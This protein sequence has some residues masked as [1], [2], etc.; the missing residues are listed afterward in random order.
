MD[1]YSTL[2]FRTSVVY[3]IVQLSNAYKFQI[4]ITH[5]PILER[6]N[7]SFTSVLLTM[8]ET[9]NRTWK[10]Q[11]GPDSSIAKNHVE[12]S[13]EETIEE[14]IKKLARFEMMARSIKEKGQ[15]AKER[16]GLD[17]LT[18][19]NVWKRQKEWQEVMKDV[20]VLK[21]DICKI[22]KNKSDNFVKEFL[23]AL[24]VLAP[25]PGNLLEA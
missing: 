19:E 24:V 3:D 23:K 18:L 9:P 15:E 14:Y 4:T 21:N 2:N 11:C 20:F 7:E 1:T 8:T 5:F 16:T 17:W 25:I 12:N 6:K 22:F 10:P 13:T